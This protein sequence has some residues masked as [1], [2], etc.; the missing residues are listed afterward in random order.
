MIISLG[1]DHKKWIETEA[2]TSR[3]GSGAEAV[4]LDV[5]LSSLSIKFQSQIIYSLEERHWEDSIL[6]SFGFSEPLT[7]RIYPIYA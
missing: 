1:A 2:L 3:D 5:F 4:A 6:H 7:P